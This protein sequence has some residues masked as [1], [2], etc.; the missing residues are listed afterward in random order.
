MKM[1]NNK[2]GSLVGE[3]MIFYTIVGIIY[4]AMAI[5]LIWYVSVQGSEKV[6]LSPIP[7]SNKWQEKVVKSLLKKFGLKKQVLQ[8]DLNKKPIF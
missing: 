6:Y 7:K 5:F 1:K 4:A 3:K 2:K 8:S